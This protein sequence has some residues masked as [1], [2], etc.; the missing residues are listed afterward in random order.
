MTRPISILCGERG[1][2]L[3][4]GLV[5]TMAGSYRSKGC[6]GFKIVNSCLRESVYLGTVAF[7]KEQNWLG[8][9]SKDV[10]NS[11]QTKNR[12]PK[13][14]HPLFGPS[15]SF[16][17]PLCGSWVTCVNSSIFLRRHHDSCYG[18]PAILWAA[19]SVQSAEAVVGC[20]HRLSVCH[21]AHDWCLWL[22]PSGRY[23]T[24]WGG[25]KSLHFTR[26]NNGLSAFQNGL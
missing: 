17:V 13:L 18:I 22:H 3:R 9:K 14:S 20:V 8:I 4:R 25:S 23:S 11:S 2:N 19:A 7:D 15:D 1:G 24:G 16:F 10:L 12:N 21:H 6:P 5:V 26:L